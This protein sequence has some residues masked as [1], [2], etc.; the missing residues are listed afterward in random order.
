[1]HR[2]RFTAY[3]VAGLGLMLTAS[4]SL[5]KDKVNNTNVVKPEELVWLDCQT[6]TEYVTKSNK[7]AE[8]KGFMPKDTFYV[9]VI[10][11]SKETFGFYLTGTRSIVWI[12]GSEHRHSDGK[13]PD[14]YDSI[15]SSAT[16]DRAKFTN[17]DIILTCEVADFCSDRGTQGGHQFHKLTLDR[18]TLAIDEIDNVQIGPR[19]DGFLWITNLHRT[20]S[21]QKVRAHPTTPDPGNKI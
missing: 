6:K 14:D 21:C 11:T 9:L 7:E 19:S 8:E 18:K 17:V 13:R 1:M 12:D 15:E 4:L 16:Y 2:S 3:G 20:G 10:N 5:A